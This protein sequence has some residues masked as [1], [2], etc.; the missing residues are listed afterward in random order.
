LER[1]LQLCAEDNMQVCY[2]TTPAQMFHLMRR[3]VHRPYRRPL[4]VMS[5][6]SL[7]RN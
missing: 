7:F 2:P 4:I 3:Q 1:F 6:K 5:P